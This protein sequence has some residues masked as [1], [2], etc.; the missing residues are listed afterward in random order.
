MVRVASHVEAAWLFL[1]VCARALQQVSGRDGH[2][3]LV[4]AWD[5]S[6]RL[7]LT[8]PLGFQRGLEHAQV[9]VRLSLGRRSV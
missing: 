2:V 1:E 3:G 8:A 5:D 4:A 6:V 9:C 7:G